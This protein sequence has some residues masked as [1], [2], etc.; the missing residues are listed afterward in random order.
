MG[1]LI[2]NIVEIGFGVVFLIGAIF[3]AAYTFNHGEEFFG[4]FADNALIKP[5]G[6]FVESV[7]IPNARIFTVIMIVF[8]LAVAVCI[9]SRGVLVK[10]GLLAGALF[11]FGAA[12]VS[13]GPGAAANLALAAVQAYLGV[14]H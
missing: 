5:V 12:F 3:N 9:L 4:S 11:A 13:N 2:R 6:Q 10:P 1:N 7:V 14:T 8:Q